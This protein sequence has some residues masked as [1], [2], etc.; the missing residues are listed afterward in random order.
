MDL[1]GWET[2]GGKDVTRALNMWCPSSGKLQTPYETDRSGRAVC[3]LGWWKQ[4]ALSEALQKTI[5]EGQT[6]ERG[7]PDESAH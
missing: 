3:H 2:F 5:Q 4:P 6:E 7:L 1:S